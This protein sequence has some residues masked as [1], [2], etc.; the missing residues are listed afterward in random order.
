MNVYVGA[1]AFESILKRTERRN[2][3]HSSFQIMQ[4]HL[5]IINA[6]NFH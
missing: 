6:E 1:I 5:Q 2:F 3:S 4:C